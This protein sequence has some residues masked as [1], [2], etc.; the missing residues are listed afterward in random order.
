MTAWHDRQ[1]LSRRQVRNSQRE[2]EADAVFSAARIQT[3]EAPLASFGSTHPENSAMNE[4]DRFD[5]SETPTVSNPIVPGGRR[6]LRLAAESAQAESSFR[7]REFRV[8]EEPAV[9][10][11][12]SSDS[13]PRFAT[14]LRPLMP[15]GLPSALAF[16][17]SATPADD[18][19]AETAVAE[20]DHNLAAHGELS[21][22]AVESSETAVAGDTPDETSSVAELP[23]GRPLTRRELRA[24]EAARET[25][26]SAPTQPESEPS[27]APPILFAP[28]PETVVQASFV[29]SELLPAE[30]PSAQPVLE[31]SF[32]L[33]APPE[34]PVVLGDLAPP[35]GSPL[36]T[37]PTELP[38]LAELLAPAEPQAFLQAP[39]PEAPAPE[40]PAA[41]VPQ[42]SLADYPAPTPLNDAIASDRGVDVVQA[43]H[44][45]P[46]GHWTMQQA[47]DDV[48]QGG[49]APT[50][51][52]LSTATGP[53]TSNALVMPSIPTGADLSVPFATA[54]GEV[55]IT[56]SISLPSTLGTTG[57]HPA[58][59]DHSDLDAI[60]DAADR[61][62][63]EGDS[64]PVR[65]IRAVSTHT[66]PRDVISMSRKSEGNRLPIVLAI[67]AGTM[68]VSVT[69]LVVVGFIFG[70]F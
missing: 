5:S 45:A 28:A 43:P 3:E 30:E 9:A 31:H 44:S 11:D 1:P 38:T 69:V 49:T 59:Y 57:S 20:G 35:T 8:R 48:T 66:S 13:L 47:I 46:V 54:T 33:S 27:F 42:F 67:T 70:T 56:G 29:A 12:A 4:P 64:A 36:G 25:A 62:D 19:R 51:R 26:E 58:R 34:A 15:E 7:V 61:D 39:A 40:A 32:D 6:A 14:P 2:A 53:I 22:G 50:S 60:I 18:G 21:S 23:T 55:L 10:D 63:I 41:F 24:L 68:M 37:S 16:L 52:D 17:P 65:A